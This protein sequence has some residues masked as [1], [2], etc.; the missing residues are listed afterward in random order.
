[1]KGFVSRLV[2]ICDDPMAIKARSS[3]KFLDDQNI[4]IAIFVIIP[5]VRGSKAVP[6]S[7]SS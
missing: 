2:D 5:I 7:S 4:I 6:S 1:M 3:N